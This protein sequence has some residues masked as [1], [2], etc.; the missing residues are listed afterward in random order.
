MQERSLL[1]VRM[2]AEDGDR[3]LEVVPN[4]PTARI[5]SEESRLTRSPTTIHDLKDDLYCPPAVPN[6]SDQNAVALRGHRD[7]RKCSLAR[8]QVPLRAMHSRAVAR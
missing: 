7:A 2:L 3:Q 1:Q 6:W 4:K 8:D 5:Q